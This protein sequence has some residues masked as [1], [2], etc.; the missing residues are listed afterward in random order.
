M[1]KKFL[2]SSE[3]RHFIM[4]HLTGYWQFYGHKKSTSQNKNI[5]FTNTVVELLIRL[6][7]FTARVISGAVYI[8]GGRS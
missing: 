2:R 1:T 3:G 7:A 6:R 8:D 5:Q 4:I